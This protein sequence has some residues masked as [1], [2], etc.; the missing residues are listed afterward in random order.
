MFKDPR[1]YQIAFLATFLSLGILTRDWSIRPELIATIFLT[2][3]L[4]QLAATI[5]CKP[6]QNP[7]LSIKSAIITSL[8]LSLLLRADRV[9]TMVLAG[10]LA[11][12]SKFILTSDRKHWFNPANFGIIMALYLTPDAWISPG[13]WGADWWYLLLFVGT[14]GVV[15]ERVGRGD[16]SVTFLGA[17]AL[18]EASRNLWLGWTW[19]VYAH[20]MMSGSLLL[21]TLFMI[22]DPRSIPNA[23]SARIVWAIAIAGLA[24]ILR[25]YFYLNEAIFIALFMLSPLTIF[26]DWLWLAPQFTWQLSKSN[27]VNDDI[28]V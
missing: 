11:I 9:S 4:T 8:G 26:L 12:L 7:W 20:K 5:T 3:C 22:T 23:K 21:F 25:N 19:D 18:L 17:Y 28:S 24:F 6:E 16:T 1:D 13:Q 10:V 27:Q 14:G 2:C 15:L